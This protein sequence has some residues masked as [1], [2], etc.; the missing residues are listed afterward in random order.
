MEIKRKK[1]QRVD[2]TENIKI[3]KYLLRKKY[4]ARGKQVRLRNNK[5]KER[6]KQ[7]KGNTERKND[8]NA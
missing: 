5:K 1:E 8:G 6:N 2:P 7:K 3:E 4:N